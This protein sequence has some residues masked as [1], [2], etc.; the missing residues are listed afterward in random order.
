MVIMNFFELKIFQIYGKYVS[1]LVTALKSTA[2][3]SVKLALCRLHCAPCDDTGAALT[4]HCRLGQ[5]GRLP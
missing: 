3:Q 1:L 5:Q 4:D 2:R